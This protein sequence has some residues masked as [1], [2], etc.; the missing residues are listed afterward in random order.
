MI[1]KERKDLLMVNQDNLGEV[2]NTKD[3]GL[4]FYPY[5]I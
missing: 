1:N 5:V 4:K 2:W 3:G